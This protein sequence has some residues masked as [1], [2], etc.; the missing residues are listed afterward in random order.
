MSCYRSTFDGVGDDPHEK[1]YELIEFL[2][3]LTYPK[4]IDWDWFQTREVAAAL[5][6]RC[7]HLLRAI[8]LLSKNNMLF[9]SA[10]LVRQVFEHSSLGAWLIE[11]DAAYDAVMGAY[12]HH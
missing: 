5:L 10:G 7:R 3:D 2:L 11:E 12:L 8:V 1:T 9:V 4:V 6:V